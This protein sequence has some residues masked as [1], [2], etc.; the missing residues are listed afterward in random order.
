MKAIGRAH[1]EKHFHAETTREYKPRIVYPP[2]TTSYP[3][4]ESPD[5]QPP[6]PLTGSY[7]RI[8]GV[9][10]PRRLYRY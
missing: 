9:A 6:K 4:H 8:G 10:Y 1:F 2:T 7:F 3:L 5:P